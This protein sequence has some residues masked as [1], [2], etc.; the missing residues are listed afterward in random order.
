M[1]VKVLRNTLKL[2]LSTLNH[3]SSI[4]INGSWVMRRVNSWN[5]VSSHSR[6]LPR[7][8]YPFSLHAGGHVVVR[9]W[10]ANLVWRDLRYSRV[11]YMT[12]L[13]LKIHHV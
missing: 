1:T 13:R 2:T 12:G 4:G 10:P 7:A 6:A 11:Q 3:R 8:C 5:V 9:V